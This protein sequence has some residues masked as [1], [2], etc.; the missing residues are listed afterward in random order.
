VGQP[1]PLSQ[2]GYIGLGAWFVMTYM[3]AK[4][5]DINYA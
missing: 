1:I 3:S 2:F 5:D 4:L